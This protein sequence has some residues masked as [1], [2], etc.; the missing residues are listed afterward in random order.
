MK[1]SLV[2]LE[3]TVVPFL[4]ILI[5]PPLAILLVYTGTT[6]HGSFYELFHYLKSEGVIRGIMNVWMP[7]FFGTKTAWL[8]IGIHA[9]TQLTL[10]KLLPGK[11]YH[12]PETVK[13]YI[14]IY[15]QNGRA[16]FF[17]TVALFILTAFILRLFNPSVIYD[18]F[19][20]IIGALNFTSLLFCV[21]LYLK[22]RFFPGASDRFITGNIIND[23]FRGTELYPRIAGWD[24]KH[25]TNSRFGMMSWPLIIL[26]FA[27]K[28]SEL[29]GLTDG[30]LVS[31]LLQL[32]YISQFFW[33]ES[34]YFS[35]MDIQHDLAGFY[36]CW[37]TLVWVP[38]VYTSPSLY[39]V[40]H[41]MP[42]GWVL[43]LFILLFGAT[44]ILAKN[45]SNRQRLNVRKTNGNTTV[46]GK[47]PNIIIAKY[48]NLKGQIKENILLASGY[49]GIARHFHYTG[50]ILGA[51]CW[52]LPALFYNAFPYFYVFYLTILLVHRVNRDDKKCTAKYGRYWEQ[53][54]KLVPYKILPG[55][56]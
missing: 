9:V 27:A 45:L 18:H 5:C 14:P 1:T 26:S 16:A 17:I 15:K 54:K 46:W 55:V 33:W 38:T 49:W 2:S 44:C 12:G 32:W 21:F 56:Y 34:G 20:E 41:P 4:L 28:Q 8:I 13:G 39:L 37:G 19:I 23:Y 11:P 50:E 10:M 51:L 36:I 35:T 42:L 52:S 43:S 6:L 53:Y 29:Y 31:V 30:M 25:F 7:V 3:N 40:Q 22:G 24:V 48:K 47:K